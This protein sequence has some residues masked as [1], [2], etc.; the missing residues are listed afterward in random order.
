MFIERVFPF[1]ENS[2]LDN[3]RMPNG[4]ATNEDFEVLPIPT[5]RGG[6]EG[7]VMDISVQRQQINVAAPGQSDQVGSKV[8]AKQ[9]Q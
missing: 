1:A 8:V 2:V 5:V 6:A 7:S 4:E 9:S 3:G